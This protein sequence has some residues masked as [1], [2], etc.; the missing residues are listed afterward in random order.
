MLKNVGT[1]VKIIAMKRAFWNKKGFK[2]QAQTN[3]F[4]DCEK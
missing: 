1:Y 4:M 3:T 2:I